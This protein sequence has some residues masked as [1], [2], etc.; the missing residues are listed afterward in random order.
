MGLGLREGGWLCGGVQSIYDGR[1]QYLLPEPYNTP[2]PLKNPADAAPP[3]DMLKKSA[4]G[5]SGAGQRGAA[6]GSAKFKSFKNAKGA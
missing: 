5:G 2:K 3:V 6:G 1:W 4:E